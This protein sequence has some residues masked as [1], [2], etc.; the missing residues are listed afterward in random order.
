LVRRARA[1][2]PL[3]DGCPTSHAVVV[4]NRE[5]QAFRREPMPHGWFRLRS[6]LDALDTRPR[7]GLA[8]LGARL[9]PGTI[10]TRGAPSMATANGEGRMFD[11][12]P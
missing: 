2:H 6:I 9:Q 1:S 3:S 8:T 5:Y 12:P 4:F 10:A 7:A 11:L